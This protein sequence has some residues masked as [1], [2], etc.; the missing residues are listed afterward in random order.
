MSEDLHLVIMAKRPTM[1]RVKTRLAKVIGNGEAYRFFNLNLKNLMRK[2]GQSPKYKMHVATTPAKAVQ[3]SYWPAYINVFD[4]GP[5]DLGDRMGHVFEHIHAQYGA[6]K[7]LIIGSDIPYIEVKHII[8]AFVMLGRKKTCFGPSGDGGYWLVGQRTSPK[9]TKLFGDVRWS[10]QHAL[11][12]TMKNAAKDEI[13]TI[14]TLN[15]VDEVED[16]I[17]YLH[18]RR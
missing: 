5:G 12:D 14:V 18:S 15:D 13:G 8:S 2:L 3:D 11:A 10:T 4:Q 9:V 6:S 16:Y 1:G 17:K 7:I